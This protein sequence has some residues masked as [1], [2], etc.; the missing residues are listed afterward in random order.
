MQGR[1]RA[2]RDEEDVRR[3]KVA[4]EAEKR[5]AEHDTRQLRRLVAER[6]IFRVPQPEAVVELVADLPERRRGLARAERLLRRFRAVMTGSRS[7]EL[8]PG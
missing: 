6:E 5:R 3:R 8:R 1:E 4:A 7:A 2:A